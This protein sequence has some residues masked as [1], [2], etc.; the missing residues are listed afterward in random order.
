MTL[1]EQAQR[2]T[3][4]IPLDQ[5]IHLHKSNGLS[6]RQITHVLDRLGVSVSYMT[7]WRWGTG[8]ASTTVNPRCVNGHVRTAANWRKDR[9]GR[10][11]CHVCVIER[12]RKYRKLKKERDSGARDSGNAIHP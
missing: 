9:N 11:Y 1:A 5:W 3:F 6:Y 8:R 12:T 2:V 7:V 10:Y 4:P